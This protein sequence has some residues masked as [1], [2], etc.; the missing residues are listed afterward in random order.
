METRVSV[1]ENDIVRVKLNDTSLIYV[2][3]YPEHTFKGLV[4]QIAN[5]AS[6]S[7]STTD[8]VTTFEVKILLLKDSYNHLTEKKLPNPFRPGMSTNVDIQTMTKHSVLTI[9][10]QAV[11]TREATSA[12]NT[13]NSEKE[14]I[15]K[16]SD[17][18][19][20]ERNISEIVFVA[21]GDTATRIEIKTGIQ[22]NRYIEIISGLEPNDE[23]VVAP[24]SAIS[25]RL[26]NGSLIKRVEENQLFQ[27]SK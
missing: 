17:E 22:D 24:F 18:D 16:S 1:N 6:V 10:I 4:T 7:G 3:A 11:T 26:S 5:S 12:S 19:A 2:D 14:G 23:V 9:P 13:E 25:R 27:T 15:K 20:I 21:K 8:Q